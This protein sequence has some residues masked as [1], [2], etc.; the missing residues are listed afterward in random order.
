[1]TTNDKTKQSARPRPSPPWSKL[2]RRRF[3]GGVL[4]AAGAAVTVKAV[5]P[6]PTEPTRWTGRTRWIGHC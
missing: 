2:S 4:A 6:A 1:M 3:L 5:A